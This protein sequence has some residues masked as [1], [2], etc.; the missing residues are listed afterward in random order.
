MGTREISSDVEWKPH[1]FDRELKSQKI[2]IKDIR[3]LDLYSRQNTNKTYV[4]DDY[5]GKFR[6]DRKNHQSIETLHVK[7]CSVKETRLLTKPKTED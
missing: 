3:E 7:K 6:N 1:P 4:Y 5:L 2:K